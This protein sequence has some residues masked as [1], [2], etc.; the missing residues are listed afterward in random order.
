MRKI[1]SRVVR[2]VAAERKYGNSN[3]HSF[4]TVASR[5]T[6]QNAQHVQRT[7]SRSTSVSHGQKTEAAVGSVFAELRRTGQPKTENMAW[8]DE[9]R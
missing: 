4:K 8:S 9:S 6:P 7:M 5:E 2:L 1:Q 3:N